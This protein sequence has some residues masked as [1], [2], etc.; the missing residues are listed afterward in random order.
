M[1]LLL[2]YSNYGHDVIVRTDDDDDDDDDD[3]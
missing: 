2:L 3:E 1:R